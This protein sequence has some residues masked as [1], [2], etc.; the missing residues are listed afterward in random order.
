MTPT[1]L[2]L[3]FAVELLIV[4]VNS[5][6]AATINSL[7]RPP[8]RRLPQATP[9]LTRSFPQL[10]GILNRL[11]I[12]SSRLVAENRKLQ[13]EYLRVR[14]EL[15]ATSSQDQFAK[16]AKLRR[17]H[18]KLLEQLEKK[19]ASETEPLILRWWREANVRPS[20][21]KR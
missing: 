5:V 1:L 20:Q 7:V 18:D 11:P 9:A 15:N 19:S 10:W 13:K 8:P 12:E 17:Q 21:S 3:I 6:G 16:W 4:I 14:L 2:L